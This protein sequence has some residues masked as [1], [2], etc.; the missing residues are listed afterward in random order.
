MSLGIG[1]SVNNSKA[2]LEAV[3]NKQTEFKRTPKYSIENRKDRWLSKKYR[4][5][6]NFSIIVELLLGLYFTFNIYFAF[7]NEIYVSI[8]FLMIFQ[9][10]YFYVAFLSLYQVILGGI[11]SSRVTRLFSSRKNAEDAIAA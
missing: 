6:I 4:M 5:K 7:I 2:V 3:F 8:P 9:M 1:L 10:G 11:A